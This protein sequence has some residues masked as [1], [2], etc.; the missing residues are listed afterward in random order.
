MLKK[1]LIV[2]AVIGIGAG[3]FYFLQN[4]Q[5]NNINSD[6]ITA[7]NANSIYSNCELG[8]LVGEDVE[9]IVYKNLKN[10]ILY[11]KKCKIY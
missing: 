5:N 8:D 4:K 7:N 6:N 2:V 1:I 11:Y 9:R 3:V 10:F